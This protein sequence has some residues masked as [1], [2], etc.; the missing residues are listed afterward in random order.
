MADALV[1]YAVYASPDI[2]ALLSREPDVLRQISGFAAD[3]APGYMD[4]AGPP[5]PKDIKRK[6]L[7]VVRLYMRKAKHH[8]TG[9]PFIE[10]ACSDKD[11]QELAKWNLLAEAAPTAKGAH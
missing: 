6:M 3:M 5:S 11:G 7:P 8:L 1:R 2:Q 10:V 4:V 9:E